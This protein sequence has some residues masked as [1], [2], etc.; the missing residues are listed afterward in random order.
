MFSVKARSAAACSLER[1]G[2]DLSGDVLRAA[3]VG[4]DGELVEAVAGE[5]LLGV[6][7]ERELECGRCGR[8]EPRMAGSGGE[9][10]GDG[11]GGIE[12]IDGQVG[13]QRSL[14]ERP[15]RCV[16]IPSRRC[17]TSEEGT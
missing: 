16:S 10:G 12:E 14:V 11:L 17:R 7:V 5:E 6:G 8:F 9:A 13:T 4:V 2:C 1:G 15:D 3:V